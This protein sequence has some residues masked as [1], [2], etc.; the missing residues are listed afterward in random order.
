MPRQ[1]PAEIP[2][3]A[4]SLQAPPPIFRAAPECIPDG[5]E[6]RHVPDLFAGLHPAPGGY[7]R[8]PRDRDG[9]GLDA[10]GPPHPEL[11]PTFGP[12]CPSGPLLPRGLPDTRRHTRG[13]QNGGE[14][15]P[16]TAASVE[17]TG[18]IGC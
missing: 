8:D 6:R 18:P 16:W 12:S 11:F 15:F 13:D 4:H 14:V 1:S 2:G 5:S 17:R 7:G 3:L 10:A 9:R